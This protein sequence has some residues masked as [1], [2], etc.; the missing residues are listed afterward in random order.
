MSYILENVLFEQ[1]CKYESGVYFIQGVYVGQTQNGLKNR[2]K[3]H[4]F[5]ALRNK[6]HNREFGEFI[7]EEILSKNTIHVSLLSPN[8]YDELYWTLV[9]D[10]IF[11]NPKFCL[12]AK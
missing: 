12:N 2:V 10:P 3:S 11:C 4:L 1:H 5:A 6:H 9:L 8:I 7:K